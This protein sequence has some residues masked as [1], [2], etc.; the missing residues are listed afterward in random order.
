[1]QRR[2]PLDM[3]PRHQYLLHQA[4]LKPY[5]PSGGVRRRAS[6]AAKYVASENDSSANVIWMPNDTKKEKGSPGG[7]IVSADKNVTTTITQQAITNLDMV[8]SHIHGKGASFSISM[9]LSRTFF[10]VFVFPSAQI[11]TLTQTVT[12][13]RPNHC[14]TGPTVGTYSSL[15]LDSNVTSAS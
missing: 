14:P 9:F 1:M 6:P 12:R 10:S 13:E 7:L 5:F 2:L 4:V 8:G 11:V 15:F 3:S